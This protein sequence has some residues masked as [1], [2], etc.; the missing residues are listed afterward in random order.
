[1]LYNNDITKIDDTDIDEPIVD[2]NE[3]NEGETE[4][5]EEST[6]EIPIVNEFKKEF[7]YLSLA[8]IEGIYSRALNTYL[9]LAFPFNYDIVDIP[10]DR[11]RAAQWVKDCMRE[12]VDRNG[13]S[14]LSYKENGLSYTWS[15]DMVSNA[16]RQRVIPLAGV[17]SIT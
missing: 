1:M 12:I 7:D 14:A 9:D 2:E 16:L 3:G 11:P 6:S 5:P 10:K 15:T 13:I 8:E 17:G 4:D